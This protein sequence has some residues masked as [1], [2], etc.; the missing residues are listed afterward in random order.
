SNKCLHVKDLRKTG[1]HSGHPPPE[2][3]NDDGVYP[4]PGGEGLPIGVGNDPYEAQTVQLNPGDRVLLYSD[5]V[6]DVRNTQGMLLGRDR[7][8]EIWAAGAD[9][10]IEQ[11]LDH[12]LEETD[13]WAGERAIEDD[14]SLL[15]LEIAPAGS[16][17]LRSG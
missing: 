7:L 11:A 5:G 17:S 4:L 10:P 8:R 14:M 16:P 13:A 6:C 9:K 15:A 2:L 1:D 3:K 12:V